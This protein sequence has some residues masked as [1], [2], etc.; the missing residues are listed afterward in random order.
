MTDAT[1]KAEELA[2]EKGIDLD[3]VEGSGKDGRIL[4]EDVEKVVEANE[5]STETDEAALEAE[6][7]AED[8]EVVGEV[9]GDPLVVSQPSPE[10]SV[11]AFKAHP[12]VPVSDQTPEELKDFQEE[13]LASVEG[14]EE[15]AEA[16]AEETDDASSEEETSSDLPEEGEHG[17]PGSADWVRNRGLRERGFYVLPD[18]TNPN[19]ARAQE[20][21]AQAQ[22][23]QSESEKPAA[24]ESQV[25][26]SSGDE[27]EATHGE[28]LKEA[29]PSVAELTEGTE[30]SDEDS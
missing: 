26:T 4:V 20:E 27:G 24:Q 7:P 16:E 18:E 14:T 23:D 25:D 10:T 19:A 13:S 29:A 22:E 30:D 2:A 28:S 15:A 9:A 1:P 17:G 6:D 5:A 3:S 8:A 21:A 11:E 12:H